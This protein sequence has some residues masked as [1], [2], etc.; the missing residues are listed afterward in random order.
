MVDYQQK[1]WDIVI[2]DDL[3]D[4][5]LIKV[6]DF[7]RS[8]L[9]EGADPVWSPEYFK[10]KL[11]QNPAG[12]GFLTCA[13]SGGEIVG[14][15][16]ITPKRI[17]YNGRVVVGGETGD[18]YSHPG[19]RKKKKDS[20]HINEPRSPI[21]RAEYFKK[22]IFGR[23]VHDNTLRAFRSGMQII[24]GTPNENS[25]PGYE[26]RLNYKSFPMKEKTFYRLSPQG[27]RA[28]QSTFFCGSKPLGRFICSKLENLESFLESVTFRYWKKKQ[29]KFGY[30]VVKSEKPGKDFDQLWEAC[31]HGKKFSLVQ[32]R[33]YFQH[34]FVDNPL[35]AYQLYECRKD[36]M[37]CG[38]LVTRIRSLSQEKKCC[39]I[40]DWLFDESNKSVFPIM[41]AH[42][43]HDNHLNDIH[44]F[45]AWVGETMPYGTEFCKLGFFPTTT[46][47]PI[48]FFLSE[49]GNRI[50]QTLSRLDFTIASSDNI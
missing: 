8:F 9:P 36:G 2:L 50:I 18:T 10:W 24:Y 12:R 37:L 39:Y 3:R 23:L 28:S 30:C 19:F 35:A 25:R 15:A 49:E 5:L 45:I 17:W 1:T 46:K 38:V 26:K 4:E 13:V 14:T 34:R 48:I 41:L 43:V 40:A 20:N 29:E 6:A 47:V 44:A 7:L 16:S 32:D 21:S 42:A 11:H 33:L 27:I 31:R 22:S